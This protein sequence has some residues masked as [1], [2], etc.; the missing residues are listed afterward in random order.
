LFAALNILEPLYE[1]CIERMEGFV[2]EAERD[3]SRA[4]KFS[5]FKKVLSILDTHP[6]RKY[7][8]YK[9]IILHNLYGVDIMDEAI[10]ICKLRL[11]LKLVSQVEPDY[12]DD[13][14]GLE[15]LPDI[16]FNIRA[17]NTLIGYANEEEVRNTFHSEG[18][19]ALL[20]LE[21]EDSYQAFENKL[22]IVNLKVEQFKN[23]QDKLYNKISIKDKKELK[24]ELCELEHILNQSLAKDFGI[25]IEK[26]SKY[27]KWFHDYK[28]FHWFIYFNGIMQSGGFDIIIGNPP[29][30]EYSYEKQGYQL[31]GYTTISCKNL[32]AFILERSFALLKNYSRSSLVI[33]ISFICSNRMSVLRTFT[34]SN[35]SNSWVS[36]YALRPQSLF[37][38]VMQRITLLIMHR[39]CSIGKTYSTKYIRWSSLERDTLFSRINY[40]EINQIKGIIPKPDL[41]HSMSIMKKYFG[42]ISSI[43]NII[44]SSQ[45]LVYFHDSGE[46]YWTKSRTAK[47]KAWRNGKLV[48]PSQWFCVRV[49]KEYSNYVFLIINSSFFYWLWTLMTDCRHMTKEFIHD[50]RIGAN[51]FENDELANNFILVTENITQYFEKRTGYVSQEIKTSSIKP[52]I[53]RIDK[54]LAS[55]FGFSDEELDFI[56]NYDIKYRMRKE[57]DD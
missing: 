46:S 40:K 38:N 35:I 52:A 1:A 22:H 14:I 55:V 7:I 9:S 25:E 2:A 8:I 5:Q 43:S 16:D 53:D 6:N 56:V 34:L 11:F 21:K 32:Y 45:S 4:D 18:D 48:D 41:D 27:I 17:G 49:N 19:Q 47:P 20:M 30:V 23:Q 29:Y 24:I 42:N 31:K 54:Y 28:P 33:P 15:P 44:S 36:N 26:E 37:D 12:N 51:F 10:E 50:V 39:N 3:N 57:A 13:N